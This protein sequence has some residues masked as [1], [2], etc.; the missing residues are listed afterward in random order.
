MEITKDPI[1]SKLWIAAVITF[2]V[3]DIVTTA[4]GYYVP[5]VYETNVLFKDMFQ[6]A[7]FGKMLIVKLSFTSFI[8][9]IDAFWKRLAVFGEIPFIPVL[10][11]WYG[12]D[13]TISNYH[14]I[15]YGGGNEIVT[16]IALAG[17][18]YVTYKAFNLP[19]LARKDI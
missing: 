13:V 9:A 6:N 11:I 19:E 2:V 18:A 8:F 17:S 1:R 3:W 15:T 14:A 5:G 10:L 7:A 16:L 4:I 12:L